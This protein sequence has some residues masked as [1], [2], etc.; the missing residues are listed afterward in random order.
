MTSSAFAYEIKNKSFNMCFAMGLTILSS[1]EKFP[2]VLM[3][4]SKTSHNGSLF[5]LESGKVYSII[6]TVTNSVGTKER[7][8]IGTIDWCFFRSFWLDDSTYFRQLVP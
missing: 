3:K 8:V 5:C 7:V 2:C 1:V 4:V 6:R